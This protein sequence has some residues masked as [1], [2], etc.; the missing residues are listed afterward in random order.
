VFR[1]VRPGRAVQLRAVAS[2][3]PA[4]VRRAGLAAAPVSALPHAA[5][6]GAAVVGADGGVGVFGLR[7]AFA[8]TGVRLAVRAVERDGGGTIFYLAGVV[9]TCTAG[10]WFGQDVSSASLGFVGKKK[11][12]GCGVG[13][14]G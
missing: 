4:R 8:E 3:G 10:G 1:A 11:G 9:W 13:G 7:A 12:L 6:R 5:W 14:T 2:F